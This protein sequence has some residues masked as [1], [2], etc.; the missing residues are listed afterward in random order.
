MLFFYALHKDTSLGM[1]DFDFR[2]STTL[3]RSVTSV[4]GLTH[5]ASA[6]SIFIVQ[7]LE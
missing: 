2:V 7:L 1:P 3:V 6:Y 5:N 4:L